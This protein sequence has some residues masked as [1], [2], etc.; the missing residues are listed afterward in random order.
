MMKAA[1]WDGVP[2]M[3][4]R[5]LPKPEPSANEA[6]VRV[7]HIGICGSDLF[8]VSGKNPRVRPPMILGHE[9][10]GILEK[11]G[12][13]G[14]ASGWKPGDRVGVIPLRKCGKCRYCLSGQEN[15]CIEAN[16]I[17][18][19]SP[20]GYAEYVNIPLNNLV[21]IPDAVALSEAYILEPLSIA[22]HAF[23]SVKVNP[24]SKVI[25]LGGGAIG[26]LCAQLARILGATTIAVVDLSAFRLEIAEKAGFIAVDNRKDDIE[27]VLQEH[28]DGIGAD[29]L[30]EAVGRPETALQMTSLVKPRGEII[31][32]GLQKQDPVGVNL[33][34]MFYGELTV[35][36][37]RFSVREDFERAVRLIEA[38][39]VDLSMFGNIKLPLDKINEGFEL[40]KAGDKTLKVVLQFT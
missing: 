23:S 32:V 15:L 31:I 12:S 6:L 14:E 7:S 3:E 25:V 1:V 19:Q 28:F 17:G 36:S 40:M 9:M 10:S 34:E 38:G 29:I 21:K 30:I 8:H 24:G 2:E 20:G 39:L 11:L 5:N 13:G 33:R 35:H 22:V 16:L 27:Q 37:K 4:V 26:I 18:H